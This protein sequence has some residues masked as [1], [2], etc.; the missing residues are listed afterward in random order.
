[1]EIEEIKIVEVVNLGSQ[2]AQV[3]FEIR[4]RVKEKL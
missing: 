2:R 4:A 1:M 3:I